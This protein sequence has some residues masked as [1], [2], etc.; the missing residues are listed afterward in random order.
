VHRLRDKTFSP[1]GVT[2]TDG[3]EMS[4][5]PIGDIDFTVLDFAGQKD[6]AH[7]HSIFFK[8]DAIY[9]A[10]LMPR[11][12]SSNVDLENFLQMVNNCIYI[13]SV[14]KHNDSYKK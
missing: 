11:S 1:G 5:I 6:Y 10:F 4:L 12:G 14:K 3:I 9:L 8:D 13:Y 7:T 2:I